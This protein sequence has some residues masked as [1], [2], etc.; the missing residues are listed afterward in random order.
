MIYQNTLH[1]KTLGRGTTNITP[2]LA[3]LP[4]KAGIINGICNIF[5]RHT[6][7]S[8]VLCENAD[9]D[10][11]ADLESFLSKLVPDGDIAFQH[12]TE[13]PDDMPAHIRSI[14]TD[15]SLTL[16]VSNGCFALGEW[17]GIY[18]YEHRYS[19]HERTVFVTLYGE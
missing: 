7:A 13:G 1:I 10:V 3:E 12:D 5:I 8:L 9:P 16:P 14:L 4:G 17:Q 2:L 6:S 19:P 11:R 18:L 15:S